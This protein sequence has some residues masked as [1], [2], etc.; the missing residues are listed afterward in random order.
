MTVQ[1]VDKRGRVV[2]T[3]TADVR[4]AV[5]G[6]ARLVAV[7][8]GDHYSDELTQ[9]DHRRLFEGQALAILRAG[10]QPGTVTLTA[11]APG[12]KTAKLK[13]IAQ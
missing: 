12:L 7:S 5:E 1:A 2:P 11:T 9:T 10:Q 3:A 13:L 4:F 6:D 8:S